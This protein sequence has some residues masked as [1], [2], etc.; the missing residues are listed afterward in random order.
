MV[1]TINETLGWESVC[2]QAER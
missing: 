1:D 2:W